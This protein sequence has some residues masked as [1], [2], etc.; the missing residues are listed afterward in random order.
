MKPLIKFA[1]IM[2]VAAGI[3]GAM[4][5]CAYSFMH[6]S[7]QER[8]EW[9]VKNISDELKLN[10]AQLSKLNALKDDLLAVRSEYRKKHSDTPK[11]VDELLSQPTLD[12]ARVLA[13]IK[14]RTQ[15]VNDKAPR[16]VSAFAA[17]YDSLTP[18]QQKKLHD[19]VTERMKQ[20]HGYWDDE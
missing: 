1:V 15:E 14:E 16:V 4:S 3:L 18:E 20:H 5:G 19:V 13:Q 9:L 7:P 2:V 11:T 6:K 8:A 17:F 12:Q 10:N